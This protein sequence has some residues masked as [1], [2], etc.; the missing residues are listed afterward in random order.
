M[1]TIKTLLLVLLLCSITEVYSQS[2]SRSSERTWSYVASSA[3]G[4][5]KYYIES[6]RY[7]NDYGYRS[8][9]V[10]HEVT[11]LVIKGRTYYNVTEMQL[12]QIQPGY[13]RLRIL[14]AVTYD[15]NMNLIEQET[16]EVPRFMEVV[17]G[18]VGEAIYE[19]IMESPYR[20]D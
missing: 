5:D 3:D 2:Y 15:T 4:K 6:E 1:K 13:T 11:W 17:P 12:W 18:S 20:N 8:S 14:K 9:W 10:K 16:I 19:A 7:V